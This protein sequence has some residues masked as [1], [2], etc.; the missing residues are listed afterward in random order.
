MKGV[1][2]SYFLIFSMSLK[3][4]T[5]TPFNF[6]HSNVF[7]AVTSSLMTQSKTPLAGATLT[8]DNSFA[9]ITAVLSGKISSIAS[10]MS[11]SPYSLFFF[12]FD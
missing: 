9:D 7:G 4:K 8:L 11:C 5:S 3:T 12:I 2:T 10:S 6:G 1:E